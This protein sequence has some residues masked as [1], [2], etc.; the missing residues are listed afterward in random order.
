M[1]AAISATAAQSFVNG[2]LPIVLADYSIEPPSIGRFVSVDN[3]GS[4]EFLVNLAKA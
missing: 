3:N 1:S 4:L 2:T